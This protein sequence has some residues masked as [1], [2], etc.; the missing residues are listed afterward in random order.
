MRTAEGGT[1][2]GAGALDRRQYTE[3]LALNRAHLKPEFHLEEKRHG[4]WTKAT[5]HD[6]PRDDAADVW[7]VSKVP[8][9][10]KF[11]NDVE[12]RDYAKCVLKQSDR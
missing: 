9:R 12:E 8:S 2:H 6:I 1:A 7:G 5:A 11:A 10:V 3:T 4:D